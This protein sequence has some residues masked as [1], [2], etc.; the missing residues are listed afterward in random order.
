[1]DEKTVGLNHPTLA[2]HL[3]NLAFLL[4]AQGKYDE[5]K[6]SYERAINIWEKVYGP[7]HPKVATGL[8]N[9][10]VLLND[11]KKHEEARPLMQRAIDIY[12]AKLPPEHPHI[13]TIRTSLHRIDNQ[14]IWNTRKEKNRIKRGNTG[15][16]KKK[17]R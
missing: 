1:M 9:L 4:S 12:M 2:I 13:T 6:S 11:Q 10:A 14:I 8:N 16:R 5:A 3:N 17:R 15:N 7:N